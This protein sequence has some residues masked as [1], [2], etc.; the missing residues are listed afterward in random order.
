L[1]SKNE[2]PE[3]LLTGWLVTLEKNVKHLIPASAASN[4]EEAKAFVLDS[5]Q[6]M[7]PWI[8]KD[9]LIRII[10]AERYFACPECKRISFNPNDISNLYCGHCHKFYRY[11]VWSRL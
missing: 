5:M 8:P 6:R 9:K 4:Q 11:K 7:I 1:I 2:I 10:S 3:A